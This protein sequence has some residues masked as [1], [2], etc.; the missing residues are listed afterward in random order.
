MVSEEQFAFAKE[1]LQTL[2]EDIML[3][4]KKH[5][6]V[7]VEAIRKGEFDLAT[8]IFATMK[9]YN[10]YKDEV[11]LGEEYVREAFASSVRIMLEKDYI[12]T[13]PTVKPEPITSERMRPTLYKIKEPQHISLTN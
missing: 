6:N 12:S 9:V 5:E 13:Y 10:D 8:T 4:S 1:N 11:K 7:D 2:I 3:F